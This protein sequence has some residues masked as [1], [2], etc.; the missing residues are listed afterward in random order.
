MGI[1]IVGYDNL[2]NQKSYNPL[3]LKHKQPSFSLL[4][5]LSI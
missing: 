2:Y 3:Y 5:W 4:R 1:P